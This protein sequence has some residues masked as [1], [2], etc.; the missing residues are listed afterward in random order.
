MVKYSPLN[1]GNEIDD[2]ITNIN[3]VKLLLN[4][5]VEDFETINENKKFF[6]NKNNEFINLIKE[7]III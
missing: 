6:T 3:E 1:V 4:Y 5:E 2:E 7:K